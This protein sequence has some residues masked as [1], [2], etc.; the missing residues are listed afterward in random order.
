MLL[1]REQT[2]TGPS[3]R[4]VPLAREEDREYTPMGFKI[5]LQFMHPNLEIIDFSLSFFAPCG[6]TKP[7]TIFLGRTKAHF[8][9]QII[10]CID[11]IML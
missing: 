5:K 1:G 10:S 4:W 11:V 2:P 7:L 9:S 3:K 6:Y 8:W